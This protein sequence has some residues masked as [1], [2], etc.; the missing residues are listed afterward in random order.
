MLEHPPTDRPAPYA[1]ALSLRHA[2]TW[3]FDLDNTLYPA[4]DDL[5][6]QVSER[7]RDFIADFLKLDKKTAYGLQKEYFHRYGT[8]LRGLM[9]RHE[10]DPKP[11]L[12]YVHDIDLSGIEYNPR[13]DK[14]LSGLGGTKLIFT[15]ASADHAQRIMERLGVANHFD[16]I[17]DICD[18]DYVPKPEPEPYD[19]LIRRFGLRPE[20][21]VMVDDIARNLAPAAERGMTTVWLRNETEWGRTG[22]KN[23]HIHHIADDLTAW[24]EMVTG[25][26]GE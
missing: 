6:V 17:F 10:M 4:V 23:G 9:I 12:S 25:S 11:F 16:G 18:A 20:K 21:A 8:S 7:I 26:N 14:V 1:N 2:G 13:L 3:V 24:L 5:F 22:A 19:S 15:N